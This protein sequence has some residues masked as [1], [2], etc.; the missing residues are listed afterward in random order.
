MF[1][2]PKSIAAQWGM[3]FG[4]L[5]SDVSKPHYDQT[6]SEHVECTV[7]N[8]KSIS[9]TGSCKNEIS[10]RTIEELVGKL[11]SGKACGIDGVY[12]E[13][14]K[15]GITALLDYLCELFNLMYDNAYVPDSLKKG[16]I[17]TLHKGGRKR[18]DIPD[19][20]RA[21]TLSSTILKLY[22]SVLLGMLENEIQKPI[23][24]LQGGFQRQMGCMMTTFVLQ[25]SARYCKERDSKLYACFLDTRQ[26]FDR[27]WHD[28][29]L[30]KLHERGISHKLWLTAAEMHRGMSSCVVHR[31]FKSHSFQVAQGTRQGGVWSPF[32]YLCFIDD[33]IDSLTKS[34][35]GLS[36]GNYDFSAP[37]VADDMLLMALS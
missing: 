26:A 3:H 36:I 23:A 24:C 20:Y 19:N 6:F 4:N 8:L 30:Y 35:F 11:K 12:Y 1:R 34:S 27:V 31:G 29:L 18:K 13:H 37:T 25:E 7:R 10:K 2:D 14:L 32:L 33:L 17:I 5:Y 15:H 9:L 28:G 16:L 22:E 21:I